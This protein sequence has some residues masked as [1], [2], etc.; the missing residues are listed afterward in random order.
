VDI[1][2]L[3]SRG[4]GSSVTDDII[5]YLSG[6]TDISLPEKYCRKDA[7]SAYPVNSYS[8]PEQQMRIIH[9]LLCSDEPCNILLYGEAGT[10]KTEFARSIVRHTGKQAFFVQ[11]GE[12]GTQKQR[13]LALQVASSTVGKKGGIL[14]VDEA[15]NFLNTDYMFFIRESM[16]KGI[17]NQFMDTSK[18]KTIWI[19]NRVFQMEDSLLRRFSYSL[20]FKKFTRKE[21]ENIWNECLKE[22]PF[23]QHFPP[24]VIRSLSEKYQVN[25]CGIGHS[26]N[27]LKAVV[28]DINTDMATVHAVVK[29][30]LTRHQDLLRL[31]NGNSLNMLTDNYDISA[32][33]TDVNAQTM[34]GSLMNFIKIREAKPEKDGFNMNLLFWGKPGTG[35]TEFAKYLARE[36]GMD[37]LIRRASD[38]LSMWVGMTEKLIKEAFEEAKRENA[39]LFIDEADSFFTSRE[40]ACRSWEISQTNELLT[41]MENH[42]GV[43]ICCTNLLHNLDKAAMRRFNWKI[44]FKPLAREGKLS[45]YMKYF[46]NNGK[47][48]TTVQKERIMSIPDLTPGDV[49]AVWQ[50]MRFLPDSA[51]DHDFVISSIETEVKYKKDDV[52]GRMGFSG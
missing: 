46:Q 44:E 15:D 14:I 3:Y 9:S 23:R 12:D 16:E 10:G 50:K 40:N 41:Q 20:Q 17:L 6:I 48:L 52:K 5:I 39:I 43:L 36:T 30:I 21:R 22:H 19:T 49:K 13:K 33:N 25:A 1:Y 8:I 47:E 27:T 29:E 45:L 24:E 4:N 31:D 51:K 26:L 42:S 28:Q 32:L 37:L 11:H 2:R 35:K 38:L 7:D 18:V 34:V